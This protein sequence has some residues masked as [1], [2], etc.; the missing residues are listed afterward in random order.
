MHLS[1]AVHFV[2]ENI[3]DIPNDVSKLVAMY[4]GCFDGRNK[5]RSKRHGY[6][7]SPGG[8]LG[9]KCVAFGGLIRYEDEFGPI[10]IECEVLSSEIESFLGGIIYHT[11]TD[12]IRKV[13]A[14]EARKIDGCAHGSG[15]IKMPKEYKIARYASFLD[16]YIEKL[17]HHI[18]PIVYDGKHKE[19]AVFEIAHSET[20]FT[21]PGTG[22]CGMQ[23]FILHLD[24]WLWVNRSLAP[25][26]AKCATVGVDVAK[27]RDCI[28]NAAKHQLNVTLG[29]VARGLKVYRVSRDDNNAIRVELKHEDAA[30]AFV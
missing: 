17:E 24:D 16:T 26:V 22:K 4:W 14:N 10:G 29:R 6:F 23:A 5:K 8:D 7:T 18:H 25:V 13:Q 2:L 12:T 1:T 9:I 20:P 11:D 27:L 15:V 19:Q 28:Q 3:Q 21:L 30:T